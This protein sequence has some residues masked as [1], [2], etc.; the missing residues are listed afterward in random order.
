MAKILFL[1][2]ARAQGKG[3]HVYSLLH[4]SDFIAEDNDIR[5]MN[6]G[7]GDSCVLTKSKHFVGS[8]DVT[9][10]KKVMQ[11]NSQFKKALGGFNP[12]VV[13]CFDEYAYLLVLHCSVFK[14]TKLSFTKCGGPSSPH[15]YWFHA[16]N[17]VLFSKENYRWYEN[18]KQY[19]NSQ[20]KLIPN[21]VKR[22]KLNPEIVSGLTKH[23]NEFT[24]VRIG[25]IGRN[26]YPLIISLIDLVAKLNEHNKSNKILK[27]LIVGVIEDEKLYHQVKAHVK[28]KDVLTEFVTDERAVNGA[29]FL[30]LADCVLGTGRNLMEAMSLNI[31]VLA[32]VQNNAYPVLVDKG[33]FDTLLSTNFSP[34]NKLDQIEEADELE[35]IKG[36]VSD[37]EKFKTQQKTVDELFLEHLFLDNTRTIYREFYQKTIADKRTYH[38]INLLY[39]IK[40]LYQNL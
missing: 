15:K 12:D 19:R 14:N 34:R 20:I 22:I 5:V 1:T 11:L 33:N 10:F 36:I 9:S 18:K 37:N 17:I 3:G 24:F 27:L 38:G 2:Y 26:Y 30:A 23:E 21:R 6:L 31:P 40:Y 7:D 8:C 39:Y 28:E 13:H 4:L 32:P 25:R 16:D 35:K 29:Q